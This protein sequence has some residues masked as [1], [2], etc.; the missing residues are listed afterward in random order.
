MSGQC[1]FTLNCQLMYFSPGGGTTLPGMAKAG[2][3]GRLAGLRL[4]FL[5]LYAPGSFSPNR[6]SPAALVNHNPDFPTRFK[7]GCSRGP[8][9]YDSPDLGYTENRLELEPR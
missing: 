8:E 4:F 3:E 7:T 5:D 9:S 1:E 6:E 2:S